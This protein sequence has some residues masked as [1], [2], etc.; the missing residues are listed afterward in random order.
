LHNLREDLS[1]R[2]AAAMKDE[3]IQRGLSEIEDT[4]NTIRRGAQSMLDAFTP[5]SNNAHLKQGNSCDAGT[6]VQL[7]LLLA[8][9]METRKW[10]ILHRNMHLDVWPS[11]DACANGHTSV[12]IDSATSHNEAH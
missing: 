4:Y 5:L 1:V 9:A 2:L 11:F 10:R 12:G 7:S 6:Q 8:T 3:T